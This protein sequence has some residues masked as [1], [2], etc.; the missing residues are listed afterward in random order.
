MALQVLCK[1]GNDR[2]GLQIQTPSAVQRIAWQ[3]ATALFY[4]CFRNPF[5]PF[6]Y[7][8]GIT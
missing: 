2:T 7:I 8:T 4:Y 3:E 5:I 1:L 6:L